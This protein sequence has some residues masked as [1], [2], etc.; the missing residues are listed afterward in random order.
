VEDEAGEVEGSGGLPAVQVGELR[1]PVALES[2]AT[3]A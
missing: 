1:R 2:G 3:V